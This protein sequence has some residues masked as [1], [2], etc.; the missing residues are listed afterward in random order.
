MN[1]QIPGSI[2][3]NPDDEPLRGVTLLREMERIVA[4]IPQAFAGSQAMD[5]YLPPS[6]DSIAMEAFRVGRAHKS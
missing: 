5:E 6:V 4:L 1:R 3:F 2:H